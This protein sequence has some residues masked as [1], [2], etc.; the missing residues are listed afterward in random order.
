MSTGVQHPVRVSHL[1]RRAWIAVACIPVGFVASM[2]VGEGLIAMLGYD[3]GDEDVPAG[4]VALAGG[5]AIVVFLIPCL[6]AWLLGRRAM[7]RGE[8]QGSTPALVAV[9]IGVVFVLLNLV[10]LVGRIAGL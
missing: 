10:G 4:P 1:T 8:P 2:V 5:T 3:S 7:A 9:T 6:V